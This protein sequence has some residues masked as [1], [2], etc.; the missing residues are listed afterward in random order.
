LPKS[1]DDFI[2]AEE[3]RNFSSWYDAVNHNP[4]IVTKMLFNIILVIIIVVYG[5]IGILCIFRKQETYS[6]ITIASIC[7]LILF[8]IPFLAVQRYGMP[9]L[10]LLI[11]P[12]SALIDNIWRNGIFY[13]K[14]ILYGFP[15]VLAILSQILFSSE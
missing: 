8:S 10:T 2:I 15:L 5:I 14:Y 6:L 1:T 3:K 12:A 11:I 13:R 9:I 7:Y 4:V